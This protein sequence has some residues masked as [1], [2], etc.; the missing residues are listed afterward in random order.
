LSHFKILNGS[1]VLSVSFSSQE[2][3]LPNHLE[4]YRSYNLP[5]PLRKTL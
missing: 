3:H 2:N 5:Y 4:L 1:I